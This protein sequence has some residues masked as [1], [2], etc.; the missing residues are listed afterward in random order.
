MKGDVHVVI[1]MSRGVYL[2]YI[3]VEG[4]DHKIEL[5]EYG[6]TLFNR[7]IKNNSKHW[8]HAVYRTMK[9]VC[10]NE[11]LQ[12][13]MQGDGGEAYRETMQDRAVVDAIKA[14]THWSEL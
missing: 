6:S 3:Q 14:G 10:E 5:C 7:A 12:L 8:A 11:R 9:A 1:E 13:L 2:P 4:K